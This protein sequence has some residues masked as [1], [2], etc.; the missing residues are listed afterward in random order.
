MSDNDI[1]ANRF[2]KIYEDDGEIPDHNIYNIELIKKLWPSQRRKLNVL[3]AGCAWGNVTNALKEMGHLTLGIDIQPI[4]IAA[5]QK[6]YPDNDFRIA[7]IMEDLS[8]LTPE[9][10][11]DVIVTTEVIEHL[12]APQRFLINMS[13]VLKPSGWVL[14]GTPYHGFFKNIAI[15]LIDG[16]DKHFMAAEEGGHIKFFSKRTLAAMLRQTGF[17]PLQFACAGRAPL[18]WRGMMWSAIKG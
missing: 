10:G 13:K 17:E 14:I 12:F 7:S 1:S 3:D 2:I 15:S 5:A 6:R 18:L 8:D 11:W 9:G 16:W 4:Y